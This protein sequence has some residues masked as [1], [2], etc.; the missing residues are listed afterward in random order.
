[1]ACP[2]CDHTMH[3]IGGSNFWCPRCGMLVDTEHVYRDYP[4]LRS[5]GRIIRLTESI[6]VEEPT[7]ASL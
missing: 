4:T 7:D 3:G 2:T 1:M 6:G 5:F